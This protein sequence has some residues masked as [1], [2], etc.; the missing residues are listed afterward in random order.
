MTGTT[1]APSDRALARGAAPPD[2]EAVL[3]LL[4]AYLPTPLGRGALAGLR[5]QR[6]REELARLQQRWS[7]AGVWLRQRG[8]F[9][10]ASLLDP[11]PLLE[12]AASAA[13]EG[14]E[15]LHIASFAE[16]SAALRASVLGPGP[17]A[18]AD[19]RERWPGLA[20]LA[21]GV[22]DLG[23]LAQ[24]LRGALLPSGELSDHASPELARLRRQLGHQRQLIEAALGREM[25]KLGASGEDA[26]QDAL[27]TVR[28]DRFVLPVRAEARRRAP[29]VV[30]GASS[31]G[32][33]V[34]VEPLDTI[35]LN[36]DHIRLREGEQAEQR[37]ILRDLSRRVAA[38]APDLAVAAR[39]CGELE[40]EA[41]KARFA[42]DYAAT[43][44]AF[45]ATV[46]LEQARH[47]LLVASLRAQAGAEVVPLSVRF[48][49]ERML[50]V[51][52]PNTGG[53]TVVLK[54]IAMAAWMAQCGLPVC[55][56]RAELPV[57]D[58]LWADI[59]DVQSI[60]Q[61]LST[62]SSHLVHIRNIL[63]AATPASMVLLDEL[64]TATNA[65]EGAALAI[66]IADWLRTRGCWTLISTHHD[67]LK[68][69]A[70]EHAGAVANG[71]VAVDAVT[72]APSYQFRMGVPGVSAGLAMAERLGMPAPIIAAAR[73]QLSGE[74]RAA[75]EYLEKLQ[76]N[77]AAAEEQ[78][79]GLEQR[80]REVAAR[81]H[82]IA[83]YD[84]T[85]Q[86]KKQAALRAEM[87]RRFAAFMEAG[88]RRWQ[89]E[90][91]ELKAS[92]SAAQQ[93]KLAAA[94]ARQRREAE[95]AWQAES[96][97]ALGLATAPAAAAR[98]A[99]PGDAVRLRGSRTAARVLR[100]LADG[101][102]EVAAGAVRL[103]VAADDLE[104]I[105]RPAAAPPPAPADRLTPAAMELNVIGLRAEEAE[106][107][108]DK[109]LDDALLAGA[110]QVRIVHGAGFG[111][112]RKLVADAL[113]AHP[114]VAR[115]AHPPQ[116]Q[117]GNGVTCA[118][119]K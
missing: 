92:L 49:R 47:P 115:F 103:Q 99:H 108:L 107:R 111:V 61:N 53:K 72:L 59:G 15:L 71:S 10:F 31:S 95:E 33:T 26:L 112:L 34:F 27:V 7:E 63:E 3:A 96:S 1:G 2:A 41:A 28:N 46:E 60:E 4:E 79:R 87:E 114:Q 22:P 8:G 100:R 105:D 62:F 89:R 13:L 78:L 20:E 54:T 86:E 84:R 35:E 29:G 110:E 48:A 81:E 67:S 36:N 97:Q 19:N 101:G 56:R 64:G 94:R 88:D 70:S 68:A 106:S 58:A 117:G 42:Q 11:R 5:F 30:H 44:V 6:D 17:D 98:Q 55:A 39:V 43:A 82:A 91:N 16:H 73:D 119:L 9:S 74:Q 21:D 116:N 66:A 109:F 80:E 50:I 37:R 113:R 76:Q 38:A 12:G 57:L 25:Q 14:A 24:T 85:W 77:L 45:G 40:L 104:V 118:E 52:G 83:V 69:W 102:Y 93:R 32:Q 75:A 90:L 18:R 51:S 65:A 23:G